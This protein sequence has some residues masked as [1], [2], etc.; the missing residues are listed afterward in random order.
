MRKSETN[1]TNGVVVW[2]Q[3]ADKKILPS[4]SYDVKIK[5]RGWK[6]RLVCDLLPHDHSSPEATPLAADQVKDSV[7]ADAQHPHWSGSSVPGRLRVFNGVV[8]ESSARSALIEHRQ[9]RQTQRGLISVNMLSAMLVRRLG[10]LFLLVYTRLQ[11]PV[12]VNKKLSYRR[13]TARQLLTW[14]GLDPPAHS[15]CAPSGYTYMR[16]RSNPKPA[17]NVRQACRP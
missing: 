4:S 2:A 5:R 7:Q 15:P 12:Y 17:T 16:I 8:I 3:V 14:R 6:Y 13:E 10:M 1:D 11:T 9:I